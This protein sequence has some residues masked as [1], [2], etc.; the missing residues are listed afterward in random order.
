[1][2]IRIKEGTLEIRFRVNEDQSVELVSFSALKDSKDLP[3]QP[4]KNIGGF[5]APFKPHQFLAAHVTGECSTG[6]HAGKHDAGSL[7]AQWRYTGHT[8]EE[9]GDGK[10]LKLSVKAADG[11]AADYFLQTYTGLNIVRTWATIR[12]EGG[13]NLGIE[14]VS[15][16]MYQ[17]IGKN[18][19]SESYDHLE[20]HIPQIGRAHV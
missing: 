15:S 10:L 2:E 1:M 7:A 11:L 9:N 3:Y 18:R 14:Y 12:N 4:P 13:E 20:F 8:V 16:F 19:R 5:D 6:M 17:G